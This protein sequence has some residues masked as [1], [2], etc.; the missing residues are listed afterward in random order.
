LNYDGDI[1]YASSRILNTF[2]WLKDAKKLVY[3]REVG[4]RVVV[5]TSENNIEQVSLSDISFEPPRIGL[6]QT[7]MGSIFPIRVTSRSEWRQGLRNSQ[8]L[9]Q[10]EGQQRR[11]FSEFFFGN[12]KALEASIRKEFQY[13]NKALIDVEEKAVGLPISTSFSISKHFELWYKEAFL[14]GN[15][16]NENKIK[17]LEDYKWLREAVGLELKDQIHVE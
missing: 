17:L 6:V 3:V 7:P 16:E 12:W 4:T 15:F 10:K 1:N 14:I 13:V 2:V 8:F 11:Y 5:E 9:Q